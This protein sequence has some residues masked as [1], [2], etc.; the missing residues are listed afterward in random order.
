[1]HKIQNVSSQLWAMIDVGLELLMADCMNLR[2]Y[3]TLS[4]VKSVGKR[5]CEVECLTYQS[6]VSNFWLVLVERKSRGKF[7]QKG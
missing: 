5:A 3:V 1:M 6:K 4:N 2:S 7:D